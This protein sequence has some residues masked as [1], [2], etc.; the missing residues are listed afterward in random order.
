[1]HYNQLQS[2]LSLPLSELILEVKLL[3]KQNIEAKSQLIVSKLVNIS[4]LIIFWLY[5]KFCS[6]QKQAYCS[7]LFIF[8]LYFL[9]AL[10]ILNCL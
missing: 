1:M 7:F 6:L 3:D 8:Y 4:G 10:N 9:N 5:R 2:Y